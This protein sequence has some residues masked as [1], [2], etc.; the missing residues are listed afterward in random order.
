MSRYD[1]RDILL[2]D[3]R[4]Y[5]NHFQNKGVKFIEQYETP[6]LRYPTPDEIAGLV[7]IPH[8]W[9]IGDRFYKLAHRHYNRPEFWWVV[10][11]F[12]LAPT[13]SHLMVGDTIYVPKPLEVILDYYE[14][15]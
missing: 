10:A 7:T 3:S 14:T 1:S 11:W 5:R 15:Y 13:E 6:Q 2:N 12:N 9:K 4:I 8:M